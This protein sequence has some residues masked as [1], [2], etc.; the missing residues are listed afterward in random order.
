MEPLYLFSWTLKGWLFG[1][2]SDL[3]NAI[4]AAEPACTSCC[5]SQFCSTAAVDFVD[6]LTD[7]DAP[8]APTTGDPN[9]DTNDS[10]D[11]TWSMISGIGI[12]VILA[13]VLCF[14]IGLFY[15]FCCAPQEKDSPHD[16]EEAAETK[17]PTGKQVQLSAIPSPSGEK[18]KLGEMWSSR[19]M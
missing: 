13:F 19:K 9:G 16:F 11:H 1:L 4:Q 3:A 2:G 15:H 12:L 14:L 17:L 7:P 6:N 8:A 18:P 5:N 10:H